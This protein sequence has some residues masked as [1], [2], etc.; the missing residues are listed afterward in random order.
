MSKLAER[1]AKKI[2]LEL[3][4]NVEPVIRRNWASYFHDDDGANVWHMREIEEH[5]ETGY[6]SNMIGSAWRASE[7]VKKKYKM[8]IGASDLSGL[9]IELSEND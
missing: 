9:Q 1:L 5:R 8:R 6:H 7:C 2:K 4:I 3:G